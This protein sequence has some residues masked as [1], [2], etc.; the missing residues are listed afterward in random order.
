MF[1]ERIMIF[2]LQ[3]QEKLKAFVNSLLRKTNSQGIQLFFFCSLIFLTGL[4]YYVWITP[5]SLW[6][7]IV[8]SVIYILCLLFCISAI[9]FG[10]KRK[11]VKTTSDA[12]QVYTLT[13]NETEKFQSFNLKAIPLT[14][15]QAKTIFQSFSEKHLSGNYTSF[16]ALVNF[17]PITVNNRLE[18]RDFSPKRPKQINRQTLLEFLSQLLIGF[19]N[20]K[21]QQILEFV[22]HYFVL[23]NSDGLKQSLSSKNISDWKNNQSAYLKDISRIF[24]QHL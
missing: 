14:E 16:K 22:K 6:I 11:R 1:L 2:T 3:M 20:L 15:I 17:T 8:Y 21:N 12:M 19:E 5:S 10:I 23:R 18:W 9:H 7:Q 4:L 24:Q 13:E